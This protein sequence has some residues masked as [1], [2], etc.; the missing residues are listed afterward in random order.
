ML[1][2]Q[3]IDGLDHRIISDKSK[4]CNPHGLM[5]TLMTELVGP[6]K[7]LCTEIDDPVYQKYL[8][9]VRDNTK[10][11]YAERGPRQGK[12]SHMWAAPEAS[13]PITLAMFGDLLPQGPGGCIHRARERE[14]RDKM[15][16]LKP[17]SVMFDR[18]LWQH[19]ADGSDYNAMT[20]TKNCDLV[21]VMGTSLSG[22]TIDNV[23][24][25][26]GRLGKPRVIFDMT[27][28]PVH[29]I[30]GKGKWYDWDSFVQGPLDSTLLDVLHRL[31][32]FYQ[33]FEFLPLISLNSL[34]AVKDFATSK[35]LMDRL[36]EVDAAITEE[37]ERE[38]RFYGE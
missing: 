14:A 9:L 17:G 11:I 10:D 21:L 36:G 33:V 25:G 23:A 4:L 15:Y 26:A 31:G 20:D 30:K 3:N 37:V 19:A 34:N 27:D 7:P 24:H 12:S 13:T 6:E 16:T 29:S 5:S 1:A 2:S 38:K 8:E 35:G 18:K 32:W 22:L 28:A